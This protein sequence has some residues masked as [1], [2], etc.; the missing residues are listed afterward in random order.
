[1]KCNGGSATNCTQCGKDNIGNNLLLLATGECISQSEC[2]AKTGSIN[3][4]FFID[5]IQNKCLPCNPSDSTYCT[6][7]IKAQVCLTCDPNCKN[8]ILYNDM[9]ISKCP[10]GTYLYE[11]INSSGNS[12]NNLP[13]FSCLT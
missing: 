8:S 3:A 12:A 9:C 5:L 4:S 7:C 1:M 2:E 6:S 10:S 13:S 11:N